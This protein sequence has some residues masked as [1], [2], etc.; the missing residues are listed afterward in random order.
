[1]SLYLW[2]NCFIIGT[3]FLSFDKKVAFYK[4]FRSLFL[5][6]LIVILIFIPW[7]IWFASKGIWGFNDDYLVGIF[8]LKLPLEEWLFFLTV[9][10]SCTFIHFVIKA[11]FK[12]PIRQKFSTRL[13]YCVALILFI[14]AIINFEQVYTFIVFLTCSIFVT[15]FNWINSAFMREF[16]ITYIVCFIPFLIV[17]GILTGGFTENPVV[18]YSEQQII[19]WRIGTIP[20]EDTVYNMLLVVLI[21]FFT[22]LFQKTRS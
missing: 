5:S 3:V 11:Y 21:T 15:I 10:Y 14:T 13:W 8:W 20:L 16:L 22:E 17:N 19:G 6:T 18:W 7:D 4:Y 9:P 12:N 1:M 2:L